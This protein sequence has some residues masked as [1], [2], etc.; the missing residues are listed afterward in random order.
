[1]AAVSN[2]KYDIFSWVSNV[3]DSCENL[4]HI[5]SAERLTDRFWISSRDQG[6]SNKL[7]AKLNVKIQLLKQL[8]NGNQ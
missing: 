2:N 1:M 5:N 4:D 8:Q 3:I 7:H 6:L